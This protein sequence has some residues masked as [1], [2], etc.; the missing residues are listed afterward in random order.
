MKHTNPTIRNPLARHLLAQSLAQI[1]RV[2]LNIAMRDYKNIYA[3]DQ[4]AKRICEWMAWNAREFA[5]ALQWQMPATL[6]SHT[7]RV[8]DDRLACGLPFRHYG[9]CKFTRPKPITLEP[10]SI[11]QD[12][13]TNLAT[14]LNDGATTIYSEAAIRQGVWRTLVNIIDDTLEELG[15]FVKKHKNWDRNLGDPDIDR[16]EE[17]SLEAGD[18]AFDAARDAAMGG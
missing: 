8:G 5:T 14:D 4:D 16:V 17:A 6:C 1:H 13:I 3:Y 2:K 9:D 7:K 11:E 10:G 12:T 15:Y 18:V